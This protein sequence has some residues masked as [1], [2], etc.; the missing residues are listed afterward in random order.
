MAAN[1]LIVESIHILKKIKAQVV[2]DAGGYPIMVTPQN[3][4]VS[5]QAEGVDYRVVI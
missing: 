3:A 2:A 5:I 1:V 4:V